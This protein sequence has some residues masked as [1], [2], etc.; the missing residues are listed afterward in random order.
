MRFEFDRKNRRVNMRL[1]ES[2]FEAVKIKVEQSGM[3]YQR[4][5]CQVLKAA[6]ES[7]RNI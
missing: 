6:I 2:L 3:L 4:F 1:P 7:D 5:I